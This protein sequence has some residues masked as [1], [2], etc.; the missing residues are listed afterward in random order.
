MNPAARFMKGAALGGEALVLGWLL[1][2]EDLSGVGLLALALLGAV[3]V[4]VIVSISWPFGAL[5][6]LTA[7]SAMPRFA[8]NVLGLYQEPSRSTPSGK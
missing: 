4:A 8:G 7:G 5:L 3:F 6:L 2:T 1:A